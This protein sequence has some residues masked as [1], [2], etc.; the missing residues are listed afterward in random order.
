MDCE[1]QL[2]S[3]TINIPP[4]LVKDIQYSKA[5]CTIFVFVLGIGKESHEIGKL[6]FLILRLRE[7]FLRK[8]TK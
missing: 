7:I 2:K 6:L 1:I 4:Q 8:N 5:F 3:V